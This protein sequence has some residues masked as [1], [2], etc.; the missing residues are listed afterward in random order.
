MTLASCRDDRRERN[1]EGDEGHR[2]IPA[3][4]HIRISGA[5]AMIGT[6]CKSSV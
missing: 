5:M 1:D 6:V 4:I 2:R 3:P